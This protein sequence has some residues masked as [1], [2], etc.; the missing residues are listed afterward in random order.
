MKK[1]KTF[2][3]EESIYKKFDEIAKKKSINKS[4]F[5]ENAMKN[6]IEKENKLEY[7]NNRES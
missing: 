7:D 2:T 6:Y 4:L 3:I 1:T 5:I